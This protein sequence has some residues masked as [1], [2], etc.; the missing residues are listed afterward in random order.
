MAP[1]LRNSSSESG[2]SGCAGMGERLL[3]GRE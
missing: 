2:S 3:N 1:V